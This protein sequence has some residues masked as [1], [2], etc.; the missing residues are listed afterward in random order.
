[1]LIRGEGASQPQ[2][3]ESEII[4]PRGSDSLNRLKRY[5]K[6]EWKRPFDEN[7]RNLQSTR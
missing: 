7:E 2:R 4:S 1:M 3:I 6:L 5:A